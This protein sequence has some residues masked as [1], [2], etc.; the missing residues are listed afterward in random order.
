MMSIFKKIRNRDIDESNV[1]LLNSKSRDGHYITISRAKKRWY[2]AYTLIN[3]PQLMEL[4][5][6]DYNY[7]AAYID[8]VDIDI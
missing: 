7:E 4:R 5:R 2:L 1:P 8:D 3:N 6:R